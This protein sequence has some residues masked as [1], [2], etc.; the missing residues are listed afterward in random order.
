MI[1]PFA[2]LREA[3]A[4]AFMPPRLA[5]FSRYAL[6]SLP[7]ARIRLDGVAPGRSNSTTPVPPRSVSPLSRLAQLA[8]VKKSVAALVRARLVPSLYTDSP[9][10]KVVG[11]VKPPLKLALVF[12]VTKKI[13]V[14]SEAMPLVPQ[15]PPQDARV[16]HALTSVGAVVETPT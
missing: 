11:A 10:P 16:D 2:T 8:G 3:T 6:P 9:S 14:P 1:V 7:S 13:D 4:I 15:M 12:P 5:R